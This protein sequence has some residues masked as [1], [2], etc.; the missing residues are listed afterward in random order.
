MVWYY[1]M[2]SPKVKELG[3]VKYINTIGL[4][5]DMCIPGNVLSIIYVSL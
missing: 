3:V 1:A 4:F 5:D 2:H